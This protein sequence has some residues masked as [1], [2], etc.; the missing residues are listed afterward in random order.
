M[1]ATAPL[2]GP[3]DVDA[4]FQAAQRAFDENWRDTTPGEPMGY[5]RDY[6]SAIR[7]DPIGVVAVVMP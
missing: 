7:R 3:A 6:T 4:A 2:S 5:P 1:Y